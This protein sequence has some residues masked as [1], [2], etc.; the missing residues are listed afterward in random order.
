MRLN[1][2]K[3]ER[4][5]SGG[6]GKWYG[7][8]ERIYGRRRQKLRIQSEVS[9]RRHSVWGFLETGY[10]IRSDDFVGW[11]LGAGCSA[12]LIFQLSPPNIWLGDFIIQTKYKL[13]Y[14]GQISL[15]KWTAQWWRKVNT[16]ILHT[17]CTQTW[18]CAHYTHCVHTCTAQKHA[19]AHTL[20]TYAHIH[21]TDTH[22]THM[23]IT[24]HTCTCT[25]THTTQYHTHTHRH[26]NTPTAHEE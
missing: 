12:S 25:H 6:E 4:E 2:S 18:V 22:C 1:Q 14:G 21:Y 20:H 8:T 5:T 19:H 23:L 7:W 3:R 26:I 10:P 9:Q 16:H 15:G 11:E 24:A 17:H 13:Y